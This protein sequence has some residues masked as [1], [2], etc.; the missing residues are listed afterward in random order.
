MEEAVND[1]LQVW[2]HRVI[3]GGLRILTI[4]TFIAF[5]AWAFWHLLAMF[6]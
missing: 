5:L 3:V 6:T 2:E 4:A 1:P